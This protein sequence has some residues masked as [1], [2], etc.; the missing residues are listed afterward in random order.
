MGALIILAEGS[1]YTSSGRPRPND[2]LRHM[3]S[4]VSSSRCICAGSHGTCFNR[5][6]EGLYCSIHA[7]KRR[8]PAPRDLDEVV[9]FM[10]VGEDGPFKIGQS[11]DPKRRLREVQGAHFQDVSL[12]R[13]VR[14]TSGLEAALHSRFAGDRLRG[15]WFAPSRAVLR[16]VFSRSD[17]AVCRTNYTYRAKFCPR[18]WARWLCY[19]LDF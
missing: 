14:G 4:G 16:F 12:V 11:I 10:R 9:Y 7:P 17:E 18:K 13:V 19:T 8:P 6:T 1:A 2:R 3:G 15:E 5:R